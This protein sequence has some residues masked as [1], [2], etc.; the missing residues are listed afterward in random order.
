MNLYTTIG[1]IL[2]LSILILPGCGGQSAVDEISLDGNT[3]LNEL[4]QPS[5]ESGDWPCWRGPTGNGMASG[6]AP[7]ADWSRKKH[8]RWQVDLPF[9]GHASPTV[10]GSQVIIAAADVKKEAELIASY[11]RSTG[12]KQWQTTIHQKGFMRIHAKNSHASATPATD[13]SRIFAVCMIQEGI[14]VTALD[15]TGKQLWQTK[16]GPFQSRHGYGSSPVLYKSLVIVAGDGDGAGFLAALHR[17]TGKLVWRVRRS[18]ESSFC[19][20]IIAHIAG[21]DQLLMSGQKKVI[22]YDPANG[23]S[24]WQSTGPATATANTMAWNDQLVFASGGY[25]QRNIMAIRADGSGDIAWESPIKVYVPSMLVIKDHLF[26]I[27]DDGIA[28]CFQAN[29]GKLI[30]KQRLGGGFSASP[31][32]ADGHI[33]V[34]NE[35]GILF[36]FKPAATF[37]LLAKVDLE[38]RCF[39]SPVITNGNMFLRT[40]NQLLCVGSIEAD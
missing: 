22:S 29:T 8:L 31:T 32:Y 38:D 33:F 21:R 11:D 26:V 37:K 9:S 16:A 14:W 19:T 15:M 3:N 25:P 4:A 24:L 40:E 36:T 30:W 34:P 28:R 2:F 27:Q 10:I 39:A 35:Q 1:R 13:G 23:K 18:Q 6:P 17:Q 20:P 7:P 12:K 5:Y